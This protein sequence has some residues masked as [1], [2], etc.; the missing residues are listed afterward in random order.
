MDDMIKKH[1]KEYMDQMFQA[2]VEKI[3]W[4][5]IPDLAENLIKKE[6]SKISNKILNE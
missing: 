3:S 2:K 6:I 1:V 4:E 5:V